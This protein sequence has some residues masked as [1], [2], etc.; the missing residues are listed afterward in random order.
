MWLI[1]VLIEQSETCKQHLKADVAFNDRL[2][3]FNF[4]KIST[5]CLYEIVYLV[6]IT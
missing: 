3:C 2:I 4:L 5:E 6:P 1:I